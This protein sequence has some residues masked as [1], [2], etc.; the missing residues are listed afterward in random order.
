MRLIDG[1]TPDHFEMAPGTA[2]PGATETLPVVRVIYRISGTT[3]LLDQ[4]RNP[5]VTSRESL[6]GTAP[7]GVSVVQWSSGDFW[8]TLAGRVPADSL[9]LLARRVR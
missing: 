7:E 2:V 3:I 4:Q 6:A 9:E 1:Q 8:L 5:A